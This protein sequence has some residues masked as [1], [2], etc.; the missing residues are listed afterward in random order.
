MERFLPIRGAFLSRGACLESPEIDVRRFSGAAARRPETGRFQIAVH[1]NAPR[2]IE[3]FAYC[4]SSIVLYLFLMIPDRRYAVHG[5][6]QRR[7]PPR[8]R[9]PSSA[10]PT[11]R[12][13]GDIA[14]S[15]IGF[16]D[17]AIPIHVICSP[18]DEYLAV[19]TA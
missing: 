5:P 2:C 12:I 4:F 18:K 15:W 6:E 16:A 7:P 9:R 8:G 11:P 19:I 10:P 1:R 3:F 13:R 14:A 17:D